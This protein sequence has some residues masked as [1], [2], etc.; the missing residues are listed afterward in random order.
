[1]TNTSNASSVTE[2]QSFVGRVSLL[3]WVRFIHRDT[4]RFRSS[5]ELRANIINPRRG[6][7]SNSPKFN[8][9]TQTI[10]RSTLVRE[11]TS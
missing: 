1:M 2:M 11:A 4:V 10:H 5:S 8:T 9:S 6:Y 7:N 3:R